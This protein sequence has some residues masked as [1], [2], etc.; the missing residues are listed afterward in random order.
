[1]TPDTI[2]TPRPKQEGYIERLWRVST[3]ERKWNDLTHFVICGGIQQL[4]QFGTPHGGW[5]DWRLATVI[6][7][8]TY[9]FYEMSSI[10]A[11][12]PKPDIVDG[13]PDMVTAAAGAGVSAVLSLA[14]AAVVSVL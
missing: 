14:V 11:K 9:F 10:I 6:A 13:I 2:E 1:M 5:C 7:V 3:T 8:W 4:W 12:W